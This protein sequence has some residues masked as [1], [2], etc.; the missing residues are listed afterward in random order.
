[1]AAGLEGVIA[2]ES[3]ICYIDGY[4]GILSYRGYNIHTLADHAGFEE[5]VFLLWNGRLPQ[6]AELDQ[7][8]KDLVANRGL[9]APVQEFLG[10]AANGNT[11]DVLRTAVSMLSLYDSEAQDMS[12][13][14][15]HRKA[16][17]LMAKTADIVTTFDRLRTGK[18]VIAGDPDLGLAANFLYTL[19]G[20]RPDDVMEHAFDVALTLHADHELNASTFAA[21]VVAA[22]LSDIY[23]AITAGI[24]ALKGPLHGGANQDVI[25]W[26]LS[27]GDQ[28]S[29]VQ[30]VQ[31]TLARKVKIPGFGHRV[32]RTEDP[33]ATHLRV[34]SKELGKRTGQE[35]LYRLSL[36]ME[37]TVKESK[38][39][40]PNVDFYSASAY[41]S[42]GIPVDL[43]TPI[44]AVSRMAGWTAHALEQY[45]NNRLIRPR[46]DYKGKPDGQPWVP[47][48]A[49]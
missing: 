41:Y 6:Q 36:A 26:L 30:A 39:L 14:A 15:N 12:T 37:T 22:T 47:I 20:N 34:L 19:T 48:G 46:A 10:D 43:Y 25:K 16:V 29:A 32:Y 27:L 33:R 28:E 8:K 13:E 1:M 2:G 23:S 40:L 24:G 49:R 45:R 21:R 17:R 4:L 31:N 3:E 7:L 44:F 35:K 5:V 38:G 11:M 18:P 42:L 9:P